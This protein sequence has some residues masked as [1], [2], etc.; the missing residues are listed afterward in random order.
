MASKG[1]NKS[2]ETGAIKCGQIEDYLIS[3]TNSE[4]QLKCVLC[5]FHYSNCPSTIQLLV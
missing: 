4:Y 3:I 5:E 1:K 2:V